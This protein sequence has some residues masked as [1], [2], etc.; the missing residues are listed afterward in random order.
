MSKKKLSVG[1]RVTI[2]RKVKSNPWIDY[3]DKFIGESGVIAFND[4]ETFG[5]N[6][7]YNPILL[8]WFPKSSI[9]RE[10]K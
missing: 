7:D 8:W 6:L 1:D 5:I 9:K 2:Y 3:M 10:V 4:R